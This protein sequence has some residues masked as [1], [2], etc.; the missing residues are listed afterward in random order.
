MT[1]F[2]PWE[3]EGFGVWREFQPVTAVVHGRD[4]YYPRQVVG[5]VSFVSFCDHF[6][7]PGFRGRRRWVS[8]LQ[9]SRESCRMTWASARRTLPHAR[10]QAVTWVAF[11][12]GKGGRKLGSA[13]LRP[14]GPL[15]PRESRMRDDG[16]RR[17]NPAL[18]HGRRQVADRT[19]R[20]RVSAVQAIPQSVGDQPHSYVSRD[21]QTH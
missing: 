12:P 10:D 4:I 21:R 7:G 16:I 18:S 11:S 1:G 13:V 15:S 19:K 9:S 6:S 5:F 20:R 2:Q 8:L 3:I 17:P 14:A